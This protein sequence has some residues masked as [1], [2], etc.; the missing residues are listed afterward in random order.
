[1]RAQKPELITAP[2]A[3]LLTPDEVKEYLR[4]DSG[5][6]DTLIGTLIKTATETLDGFGGLLGRAL[7]SQSWSQKFDGFPESDRI[8]LPV[9]PAQ[10]VTSVSY[11][12]DLGG[13]DKFSAFHLVEGPLGSAI[14]LQDTVRW[15]TTD[16]RPDAVTVTWDAGF[17]DSAANVP[18]QIKIAALQLV[19][20][21]Y[22][23]R[24]VVSAGKM[25]SLPHGYED[26]IAR[27]RGFGG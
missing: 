6:E 22:L 27:M 13:E 20:H 12:N 11:R 21:L 4:I 25:V 19:G 3:A 5:D 8:E 26:T 1:M 10:S 23:H 7:I 2:A 16:I 24:D 15:P 14:V 17:G 18:G 9:G